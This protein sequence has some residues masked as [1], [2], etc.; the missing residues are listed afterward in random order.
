MRSMISQ[1]AASV[2]DPL[3]LLWL[4]LCCAAAWL[5][6]KRRW[7]SAA[8]MGSP[9]VV[10][11]LLGSLP[12]PEALVASREAPYA[13]RNVAAAP[14][15]DAVVMLGGIHQPSQHDLFGLVLEAG[16][17]R[18]VT[19]IEVVRQGKARALVLG[20]SGSLP[21][22]TGVP[23]ASL[24][25]AWARQ[26]KL[27]DAEILDLGI[28][29]NTHDEALRLQQLRAERGWKQVTIATSALHMKRAEATIRK[30]NSEVA[31][32]A[33]DFRVHGVKQ[34]LWKAFPFPQTDRIQLLHDYL[35]EVV[36]FWVYRWRGWI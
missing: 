35:H 33:C 2:V 12:W 23:A 11:F 18:F 5:G 8:V 26:W 3:A 25:S 4:G 29:R 9:A 15:T 36:G 16:G 27:C 32:V 22:Q 1:W 14:R 17:Q 6:W 24:L 10:L 21:G 7:R 30:L 31:T 20:G 13:Q 28:C 19:A 34:E